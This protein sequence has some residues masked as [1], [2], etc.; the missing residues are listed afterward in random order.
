MFAN[1]DTHKEFISKTNSLCTSISKK[2]HNQIGEQDLSGHF[3]KE[4]R[5][6]DEA[7][8]KMLSIY[9]Y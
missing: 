8:E 5:E 2:Q 6:D 1:K 9:K 7:H 3:F 4:D